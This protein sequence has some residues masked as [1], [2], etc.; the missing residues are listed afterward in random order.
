M[1]LI[2]TASSGHNRALANRI[3]ELAD[4]V[5]M[6][7]AVLDLTAV[8]LPLYT[9]ARDDAGRP[10]ALDEIEPAFESA[11]GF[12]FCAPEYNGSIPPTLTNAIAWLSTQSADFRSLFNGKPMALATRSGG[13]GQKVLVAMRLQMSHL[14]GNV[15]GRELQTSAS[16]ALRDESVLSI[17]GQLST[18]MAS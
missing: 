10:S 8:D 3:S 14:G 15:I 12:F 1:L 5:G 16:K 17:L 13:G 4:T 7:N 6:A 11:A 18:G 9:P 2:C